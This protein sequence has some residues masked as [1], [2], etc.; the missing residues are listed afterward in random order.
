MNPPY[1]A[2]AGE[3][4]VDGDVRKGMSETYVG[5]L[6]VNDKM[7]RAKQ[8]LYVQ[9]MYR[10]LD[11]GVKN[12][13]IYSKPLFMSGGSFHKF[14]N[15]FENFY[16]FSG[17]FLMDSSEFADVESWGLSFTIWSSKK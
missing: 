1:V 7:G 8:Q 5:S 15:K 2:A 11:M 13:A 16:D 14:L 10:C 9:F 3:N 12:I 17:G 4:Y 6:M